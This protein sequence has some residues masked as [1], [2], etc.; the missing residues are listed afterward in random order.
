MRRNYVF[1][2]RLE[3]YPRNRPSSY[4][5]ILNKPFIRDVMETR[6]HEA[7]AFIRLAFADIAFTGISTDEVYRSDYDFE[8]S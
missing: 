2:R 3:K 6:V 5:I 1:V 4:T 7:Y 8:I